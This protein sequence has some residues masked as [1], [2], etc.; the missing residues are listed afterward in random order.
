MST[1]GGLTTASGRARV[2]Q[3]K[4]NV[5]AWVMGLHRRP[6][7]FSNAEAWYRAA[8]PLIYAAVAMVVLVPL[9]MVASDAWAIQETRT[10]PE[11]A[12]AFFRFVT[13]FGKSGWFLWPIGLALIAFSFLTPPALERIGTAMTAALTV[14]LAFLF[15]AIA[16]PGLFTAIVKRLIGRAR[17]FVG[18][19]ADPYLYDPFI[20][21]AAYASLPSGH[22]TTAFAVAVAFGTLWPQMRPYVWTYAVVIAVSRVIVLAHHPSD[23]A[24]GAVVGVVGAVLVGN[25]FTARRMAFLKTADGRVL[26]MPGPSWRRLKRV[27]ARLAGP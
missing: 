6:R 17:P 1:I 26:A 16:I 3:V 2:R 9:V 27:A 25:W 7:A 5:D 24:A 10:L 14:R 4:A 19:V 15:A 20:W 23:V 11:A 8:R 18:G 22:A 12:H 13:E 21:N